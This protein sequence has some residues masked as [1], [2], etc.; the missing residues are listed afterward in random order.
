MSI[1]VVVVKVVFIAVCMVIVVE[2]VMKVVIVAVIMIVI[3][4]R[5]TTSTGGDGTGIS[6]GAIGALNVVVST[7]ATVVSGVATARMLFLTSMITITRTITSIVTT[8]AMSVVRATEWSVGMLRKEV[9]VKRV[10]QSPGREAKPR[11]IYPVC[12]LAG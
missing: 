7:P 5:M 2:I 11:V 10:R 12:I 4:T 6:S 8:V 1:A 9:M 3:V